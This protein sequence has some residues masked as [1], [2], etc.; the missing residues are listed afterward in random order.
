MRRVASIL[1]ALA[2]AAL[3]PAPPADGVKPWDARLAALDPRRPLEYLELA[4]EIADAVPPSAEAD[5]LRALA[6]RLFALAGLLDRERL[7]R[8]AALGLLTLET[9]RLQR[10]RLEAVARLLAPTASVEA[11]ASGRIDAG[12]AVAVSEAFS[13]LRRGRGSQGTS[14]LRTMGADELLE[15]YGASLPGGA[16]RFREDLKVFRSGSMR[17]EIDRA[18][19]EAMFAIDDAVLAAAAERPDGRFST[20]LARGGDAPLLEVDT[21]RLETVFGT[22][23]SRPLWRDGQWAGPPAAE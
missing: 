8:S 21:L 19:R 11:A 13:A 6:K 1:L 15:R 9:D 23:L 7:G 18:R 17:P 3:A 5:E 22:D 4:E 16:K 10:T 14:A 2:L 12:A 20:D